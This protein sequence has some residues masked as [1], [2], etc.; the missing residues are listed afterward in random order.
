[1]LIDWD[2]PRQLVKKSSAKVSALIVIVFCIISILFCF[3]SEKF[4][5]QIRLRQVF[6]SSCLV[7]YCIC[8]KGFSV[9]REWAEIVYVVVIFILFFV[10][11]CT[12][13]CRRL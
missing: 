11:V 6:L 8:A 5:N 1:M 4:D 13:S 9:F 10:F 7:I 12:L 3:C 2:S